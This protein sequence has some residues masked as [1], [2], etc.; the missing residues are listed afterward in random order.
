MEGSDIQAVQIGRRR[1]CRLANSH[2]FLKRR[3]R[4]TSPRT[5]KPDA[6]CPVFMS[7]RDGELPYSGAKGKRGGKG[8]VYFGGERDRMRRTARRASW[9]LVDETADH[10]HV[11]DQKRKERGEGERTPRLVF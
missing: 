10:P 5:R 4:R 9:G 6:V 8:P 2:V 7:D 11:R 1:C 3:T